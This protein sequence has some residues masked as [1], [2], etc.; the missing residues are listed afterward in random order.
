MNNNYVEDSFISSVMT[1][2]DHFT[3][4]DYTDT[5][6]LR[7]WEYTFDRYNDKIEKLSKVYRVPSKLTAVY[8]K[9]LFNWYIKKA[10]TTLSD[11]LNQ[12]I[13]MTHI[14]KLFELFNS[15]SAINL[16]NSF[17]DALSAISA[18]I[19]TEKRIGKE[20]LS[21]AVENGLDIIFDELLKCRVDVYCRGAT[22]ENVNVIDPHVYIFNTIA[23]CV[24]TLQKQPD[25]IYICYISNHGTSDGYFGFFIKNN[26][27][28]IS[29]N[30]RIPEAFIGQHQHGRNHRFVED[31][32]SAIFP[33]ELLETSNYDYKG[34]ARTYTLKQLGEKSISIATLGQSAYVTLLLVILLLKCR[35]EGHTLHDPVVYS[36]F[37]LPRNQEML[38]AHEENA[39]SVVSE[40]SITTFG[41]TQLISML[42][43]FTSENVLSGKFNSLFD[44]QIHPEKPHNACGH[45]GNS[46]F[47]NL[48]GDGFVLDTDRL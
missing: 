8:L 13:N 21:A 14:S 26:G 44:K 3:S 5:I 9:N 31:K 19:I 20:E 42:S 40:D 25:A 7:S 45:F 34:Y 35:F 37:Y 29:V 4:H 33:Y 36:T 30:E 16:E 6:D 18:R 46:V 23:E 38:F 24:P 43:Q 41:S 39:L 32:A 12:Q 47:V 10:T 1:E 17:Y 2:W 27:N 11:V 22:M 28:L 48:Y 15:E